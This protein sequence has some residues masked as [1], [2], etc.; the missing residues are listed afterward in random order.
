M[1]PELTTFLF[2]MTPIGEI[3]A[4]VIWGMTYGKL[5]SAEALFW[6]YLGNV[7]VAVLIVLL[8]PKIAEFAR[9]HFQPINHIFRKV[10]AK[11]R[12]KHSKNFLRFA[13]LSLLILV[14][15]PLPGSGAYTG[16]LVAWLFGVKPKVAI[17]LIAVGIFLAGL[18]VLGLT[19]GGLA[20]AKSF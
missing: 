14:A 13:E 11:T 6:G 7:L 2:G 1:P 9:Q 8:L 15:V 16:A 17:P 20:F 5:S 12:K 18:I 19:N 4:A 10:F 3:R